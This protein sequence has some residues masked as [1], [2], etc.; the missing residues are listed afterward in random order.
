MTVSAFITRLRD[1]RALL[2]AGFTLDMTAWYEWGY[3]D[4]LNN[5]YQLILIDSRSR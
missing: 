1:G 3:V 4:A 5:D 2:H